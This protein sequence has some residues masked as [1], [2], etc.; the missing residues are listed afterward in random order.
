LRRRVASIGWLRALLRPPYLLYLRWRWALE[1]RRID[2]RNRRAVTACNVTRR[3]SR[4]AYERLYRDPR[5]LDEYL[6][7]ARRR[8]YD[9]VVEVCIR[10]EPR[11]V[12]DV[13]C[14]TGN[15]LAALSERVALERA[16]GMDH[17][18]GGLARGRELVP[19][20]EFIQAD[21]YRLRLPE[22]F[23]LVVCTEV[24]EH[25]KRPRQALETLVRLCAEDGVIIA[26][27][28]DGRKDSWE[29]HVNFWGPDEFHTLL[30]RFGAATVSLMEDDAA[31][32]GTLRPR[33]K[34]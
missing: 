10:L 20:A 7:P 2:F 22:T 26:T 8:F 29:G 24:L 34:T 30:S 13:G 23:D 17:A 19:S 28:P 14:G 1:R 21:I 5:L 15:L 18:A 3:N 31:L 11:R 12:V 32:L 6:A 9:D 4:R 25:L 33:P 27:V 16:V